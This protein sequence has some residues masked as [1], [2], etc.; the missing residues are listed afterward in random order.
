MG[1]QKTRIRYLQ[2]AIRKNGV[3]FFTVAFI[4]A[5]S[6]AIYLG[7]QS[8][9]LSILQDADGYFRNNKLATLEFT[10]A[11]GI[12]EADIEAL[13]ALPE[14]DQVEGGY[15]V[16]VQAK[17]PRETI[18]L[19]AFSRTVGINVPLVLEGAL[20]TA[21]DEV[22]IE[23]ML[24]VD[25]AL[26]VGDTLTVTHDGCLQTDTFRITGIIAQPNYCC[27]TS[28]D[29]RGTATVGFGAAERYVLLSPDAFATAY[30]G[31]TYTTA[32]TRSEQLAELYYY[33]DA[34]AA[35]EEALK[36]KLSDFCTQR[37]ALRYEDLREAAKPAIDA[38]LLSADD[39]VHR[40]W[41]CMG[42]SEMGD[43]LSVRGLVESVNGISYSMSIVFLLVAIVICHS[44]ISRMIDEERALIGAQKALGSSPA[45][46]L[47]H[48]LAYNIACAGLGIL[49]GWLL[50]IA[51]IGPIV[52]SI[53]AAEFLLG[54]ISL[55]FAWSKAWITGAICLGVF[56]I[57]TSVT[58][59]KLVKQQTTVL[60]QG[61]VPSTGKPFFFEKWKGYK[62]MSLYNRAMVKNVLNDPGRMMSTIVGVVGC[63]S[64]LVICISLK[65]AI[66][67]AFDKQFDD[68]FWYDSRLEVNETVAVAADIEGAL[69]AENVDYL[70]I[71]DKIRGFQVDGGTFMNAHLVAVP[72]DAGAQ[73]FMFFQDAYTGETLSLPEEGMLISRKC[74]E[75]YDLS[76]GDTLE[77]M[78][79]TGT[80]RTLHV[81]GVI[82]HY[83]QYHLFVMSD[84]YYE[85][86]MA[87][88]VVPSVYLLRAQP[89]ALYDQLSTLPGFM[90]LKD[91]SDQ[92]EK[93]DPIYMA[94]AVFFVLSI[95]MALLVLLNQ[96]VMHIN[97]KARE[98]AVMRINGYTIRETKAY[99]YKDNILLTAIGLVLGSGMGA[100]LSYF[101]ITIMERE[102]SCYILT[103]QPITYVI[104]CSIGIVFSI[105]VNLIALRRVE[106]LNLTN[107]S[108]N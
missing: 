87:E 28:K 69:A 63:I 101:V 33:G 22:A 29:S 15:A 107:V 53:L 6:M 83:L 5:V 55:V 3:S 36:N 92:A 19:R 31:N 99:I 50:S 12:T 38:G 14:L 18:N 1:I 97:R 65:V 96:I 81:A 49:L 59:A 71:R 64:L 74:A 85:R 93:T 10:C 80:L 73:D 56:V 66:D 41:M 7:M 54:S 8:A 89:D 103:P 52:V 9:T 21:P 11:N 48:Y 35:E 91:N 90:S 100:L 47:G 40:D 42:R 32:Y 84:K 77:V 67:G 75:I 45:S 76:T 88:E 82:E 16:T 57:T 24:A 34:Y 46:I 44:A 108:G 61:I 43:L 79:Q 98:L 104:A 27:G 39:I 60:L 62:R 17:L 105:G 30:F 25:G 51:I 4:A 26:Q 13:S 78:D 95:I 23:E 94:I 20:P 2:K 37:A 58:C 72:T 106:Q 102:P 68:Y 86:A 70:P